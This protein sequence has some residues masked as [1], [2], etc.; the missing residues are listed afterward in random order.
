[1]ISAHDHTAIEFSNFDSPVDVRTF[2]VSCI[3]IAA[4][5]RKC[6]LLLGLE[7]LGDFLPAIP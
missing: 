1:M 4:T 5:T 3:G 2:A 7:G 6:G